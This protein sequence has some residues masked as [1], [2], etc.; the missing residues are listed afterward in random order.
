MELGSVASGSGAARY[1]NGF[2]QATAHRSKNEG[3]YLAFGSQRHTG[4]FSGKFCAAIQ[5]QTRFFQKLGRKTHVF[6]AIYAPKP[7]LFFLA[8]EKIQSP[9]EFFHRAIE[10]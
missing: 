9:F 10:G 8:L 2:G 3:R 1:F 4:S 7:E 6:G 5:P